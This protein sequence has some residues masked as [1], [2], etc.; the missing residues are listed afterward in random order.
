MR[1]PAGKVATGRVAS[2]ARG[3]GL[4]SRLPPPGDRGGG[5]RTLRVGY[6]VTVSEIVVVWP[7]SAAQ[8]V[9]R[10]VTCTVYVPGFAY[11]WVA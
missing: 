8:L 4:H 3:R 2:V 5:I 9:D 1:E 10:T 7:C 11:S 6:T